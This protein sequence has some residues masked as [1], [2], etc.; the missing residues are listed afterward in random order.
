[1]GSQAFALLAGPEQETPRSQRQIMPT[2]VSLVQKCIHGFS[3]SGA[4]VLANEIQPIL[5]L[6]FSL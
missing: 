2:A 6:F 1:M 3:P 5:D 4:I